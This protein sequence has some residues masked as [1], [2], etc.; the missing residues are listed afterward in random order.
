MDLN[1][2]QYFKYV[3]DSGSF[4]R[5]ARE[6]KIPK[7][8]L[9]R[10]V[11]DLEKRLGVTLLRR[12]T[13]QVKL[14]EVGV[15]YLQRCT[16]ILNELEHASAETLRS[17]EKPQGKLRITGPVDIGVYYLADVA[18]EFGNKY[19]EVELEFLLDDAFIDL[20]GEKIDI[21]IRAGTLLDSSL[22][23]Q[24]LGMSEFQLFAS[25]AYIKKYGEPKSVKDLENHRCL[26]FT[27]LESNGVWSL[28]N[29]SSKQSA[30]L[31]KTIQANQLSMVKTLAIHGAGIAL[32]PV[33][34]GLE[35]EQKKSLVRVLKNWGT[36]R[37]PVHAVYPDQAYLP[38]RTR[39]FLDYLKKAFRARE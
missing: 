25:P 16:R 7:S 36:D 8:T 39:L 28:T 32:I 3:A 14:T 24:K 13:R 6:T 23:A 30:Q 33:F 19:P 1:E 17:E 29:G 2:I 9:S 37:E 34:I 10:K 4:S 11:A 5:A 21:A 20:M 22:K 26:V 12:T 15:E 27:S 31:K 38:Q 35:E 18:A